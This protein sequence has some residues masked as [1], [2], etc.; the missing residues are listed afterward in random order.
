MT[1]KLSDKTPGIFSKKQFDELETFIYKKTKE[2][3]SSNNPRLI[4]LESWFIVDWFI[5]QFI[6]SGI[7]CFDLM[8]ERFNPHYQLLPN[9][10]RECIY[11]LQELIESQK[12]LEPKPTPYD[13]GFSGSSEFW[14]FIKQKSPDTYNKICNLTDEFQKEKY[15]LP[16]EINYVLD[17]EL[18]PSNKTYRFVTNEW[19]NDMSKINKN[20]IKTALKLNKARND[21]AH[22]LEEDNLYD[23]FGIKGKNKIERLRNECLILLQ[24]VV[25][26]T[27]ENK[28]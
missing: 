25:G 17:I 11:V 15:N 21:A 18:N 2:I 13:N 28:N 24:T 19:L 27:I 14:V 1:Y 20:W 10:F 7:N 8:S 26:L 23:S 16:K 4:I 22:S 6:I 9:S 12:K 5:R 3:E